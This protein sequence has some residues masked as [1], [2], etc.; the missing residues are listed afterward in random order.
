MLDRLQ[1]L[2]DGDAELANRLLAL[3]AFARRIRTREYHLTNACNLRCTGCWFFAY[4]FDGATREARSPESWRLF[5]KEQAAEGTTAA[6]LIGGEPAL[7]PERVSAFVDAMEFVTISSN[8]LRA[9]PRDGFERVAVALSLFG[10]EGHDDALRAIRPSGKR[11]TGLFDTVLRHYRD[12]PRAHFIYA[13]TPEA[14]EAIEPTVRRIRDNGNRVTFNYYS[15]YGAGS[16]DPVAVDAEAR[17]LDEALR[18]RE[19]YPDAVGATP[20]YLRTIVTGRTHWAEWSYDVCPSVSRSHPAHAA[21]LANGNPV[22]PHFDA[23]AAD[24]E[25]LNFCCASGQCG[26]CRDSQAMYSWLLVSLPHFLD[27]KERLV[28]W[29]G[30]AESY[31]A[32]FVWSPYR[33]APADQAAR[34][35]SRLATTR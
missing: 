25:T 31:W 27:T 35:A 32:Q 15:P 29:V 21:R 12:D 9:L 8:G 14:P 2:L 3:R 7:F 17:L 28:E 13:I 11:F 4:D 23:Y 30:L 5:A 6:L 10:G 18:V 26:E 34:P 16:R 19:A 33:D 24:Q 22:L 20:L 1:V